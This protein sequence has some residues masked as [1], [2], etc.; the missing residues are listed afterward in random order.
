MTVIGRDGLAAVSQRSIAAEAGLPPSAVY[1]Y[2]AT[3]DDLVAAVLADVND[4]CL[5]ELRDLPAGPGARRAVAEAVVGSTRRRPEETRAELELW[6]LGLRDA[7]L[8]G[9]IERWHVEL[10]AVALRLTDDP[11]AADAVVAIL[12]GY[13]WQALTSD[14]FD[15]DRLDAILRHV[16]ATS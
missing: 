12:N 3:L 8:H 14:R 9:E 16:C 11:V 6:L 10:H 5:A 2:F 1:Y 7:T 13:Y 15:V 4:R